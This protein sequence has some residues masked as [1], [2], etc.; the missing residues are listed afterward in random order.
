MPPIRGKG[1]VPMAYGF[2]LIKT[3]PGKE[4]SVIIKLLSKKVVMEIHTVFGEYD[5][6]ALMKAR[7]YQGLGQK[8]IDHIRSIEGVEDTMTLAGCKLKDMP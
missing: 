1:V 2:V 5:I 8:I 4:R 7:D 6:V 3:A